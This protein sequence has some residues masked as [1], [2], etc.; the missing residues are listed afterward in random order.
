MRSIQDSSVS[1]S[2][3]ALARRAR[4]SRAILAFSIAA[5]TGSACLSLAVPASA[6]TIAWQSATDVAG[7]SDIS[8][9]GTLLAAIDIGGAG[10]TVNGV[11]FADGTAP[12]GT[13]LG[14]SYWD[15]G[16]GGADQAGM[17]SGTIA[18]GAY[19]TMLDTYHYRSAGYTG[20]PLGGTTGGSTPI[21]ALT[22]GH[23]YLIQVWFSDTRATGVDTM[24]FSNT[25]TFAGDTLTLSSV[26]SNQAQYAI[27]T[28]TA[29]ATT[30]HLSWEANQYGAAFNMIQIRDIT[31]VPEP[32]AWVSLLGGCGVLLGLRRR[33]Y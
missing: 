14:N 5:I 3:A 20:V 10:G 25:D 2:Q 15:N 6:A 9:T 18:T 32:G 1:G 12:N 21:P 33:R 29:D 4:N 28:F 24:T 17:Y 30:Q 13:S 7:D 31:A 11:T 19:A 16:G 27:G 26:G 23:Q 22:A 8:T